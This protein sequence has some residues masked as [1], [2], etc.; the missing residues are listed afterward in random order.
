MKKIFLLLVGIFSIAGT[1]TVNAQIKTA[2]FGPF[3]LE[4]VTVVGSSAFG[5]QAGNME[6]KLFGA[7]F[8]NATIFGCD[9]VYM[10]TRAN[11]PNFKEMLS[12]LMAAQIAQKQIRLG[13]TNDPALTAFGGR[14]SLVSVT[15]LK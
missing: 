11:V 8:D 2:E 12:A 9:A 1:A 10:A 6:I 15:I 4:A 7:G 5:H 13:I 3:L 14:C